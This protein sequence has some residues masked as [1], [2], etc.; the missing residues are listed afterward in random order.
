MTPEEVT[1]AA[2]DAL[3]SSVKFS[4]EV[5]G[6][7]DLAKSMKLSDINRT[8]TARNMRRQIALMTKFVDAIEAERE[9][10]PR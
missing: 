8:G 6:L 1:T 3:R 2:G 9:T 10:G 5:I 4:A 7:V